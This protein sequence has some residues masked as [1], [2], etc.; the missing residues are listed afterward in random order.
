MGSS[1]LKY[2]LRCIVS[3]LCKYCI[4]STFIICQEPEK[5][6]WD[7][8]REN[9]EIRL[10]TMFPSVKTD[11]LDEILV[12]MRYVC[13][14]ICICLHTIYLSEKLVDILFLSVDVSI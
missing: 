14:N 11:T 13:M 1:C 7:L 5:P 6:R 3:D 10:Y 4:R 2:F 9:P 8:N 12:A